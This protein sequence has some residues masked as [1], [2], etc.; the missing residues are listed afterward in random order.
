MS[1]TPI[2]TLSKY[3]IRGE[4]GKGAMGVVYLGFDPALE[5]EVAIKV[6]GGATVSDPELKKR[7]EVEAKASAKLQHPNIVTVLRLRVRRKGRAVH[8][9][10]AFERARPRATYSPQSADVP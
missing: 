4:L 3:Q 5:R 6:M 10:G 8:G 2:Q 7:F 9:D 1:E